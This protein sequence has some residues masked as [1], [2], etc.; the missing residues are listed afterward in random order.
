MDSSL[1]RFYSYPIISFIGQ[2]VA[3]VHVHLLPRKPD[4][5]KVMDDVYEE[6]DNQNLNEVFGPTKERL[7]RSIEE[8]AAECVILR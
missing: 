8:M 5:F 2:S 4:D 6:L 1:K 3:H 7:A